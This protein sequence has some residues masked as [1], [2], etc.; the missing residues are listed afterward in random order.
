M[1]AMRHSIRQRGFSL[2]E[3]LVGLAIALI[4]IVVMFKVQDTWTRQQRA[5]TSGGD[6]HIAGTVTAFQLERDLRGAGMGF[7][8]SAYL[9]CDIAAKDTG[10]T[11][12]FKFAPVVITNGAAGASDTLTILSGN[13]DMPSVTYQVT[14]SDPGTNTSDLKD[15]YAGLANGNLV[16]VTTPGMTPVCRLLEVTSQNPNSNGRSVGHNP[17]GSYTRTTQPPADRMNTSE[18]SA[19]CTGTASPWTC[20]VRFIPAPPLLASVYTSSG[21]TYGELR[22]LGDDPRLNVWTVDTVRSVLSRFDCLHDP[23]ANS[24]CT[25][26]TNLGDIGEGVVN[27]QAQYGLDTNSDGAVDVWQDA[28]PASW[29]QVRMIRF[30][31]LVR[32]ENYEKDNVNLDTTV[33]PAVDRIPTWAGGGFT[34]TNLDGTTDAGAGNLGVN[35]WRNYRYNVFE[36]TVPLRNMIWTH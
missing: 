28:T 10:R 1:N 15:V 22:S 14:K 36:V 33:F 26:S 4:G 5:A 19:V 17:A 31:L 18:S 27:L 34:M 2:I 16:V 32:G 30:A 35:N 13:S 21:T 8:D 20:A 6:A 12:A 3:V 9:G 7:G 29:A 23:G 25:S 24:T 11:L